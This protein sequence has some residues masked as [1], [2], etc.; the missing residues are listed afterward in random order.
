[1]RPGEYRSGDRVIDQLQLRRTLA[2]LDLK[3]V[4]AG[5]QPV[6]MPDERALHLTR[7]EVRSDVVAVKRSAE[8]PLS[9][10]GLD[11]GVAAGNHI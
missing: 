4:L 8:F 10:V 6:N 11:Q 3:R 7:F 9:H 5:I 1:M 2:G